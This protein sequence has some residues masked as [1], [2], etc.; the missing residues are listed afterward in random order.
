MSASSP[1]PPSEQD[2]QQTKAEDS[3]LNADQR[4]RT[5][6][7]RAQPPPPWLDGGR[8]RQSQTPDDPQRRSIFAHRPMGEVNRRGRQRE[9]GSRARCSKVRRTEPPRQR[10]GAPGGGQAHDREKESHR[11]QV[12]LRAVG[13]APGAE[14]ED[15]CHQPRKGPVSSAFDELPGNHPV[16]EDQPMRRLQTLVDFVR[17]VDA[18]VVQRQPDSQPGADDQRRKQHPQQWPQRLR[19][20]A[21]PLEPAEGH[22]PESQRGCLMPGLRNPAA[23]H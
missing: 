23:P 21:K 1:L 18:I 16:S 13:A 4:R 2:S 7:R 8:K 6:H 5:E 12:P 20:R 15:Q 14:L 22:S 19:I 9:Q 11:E 3:R 17:P 10:I